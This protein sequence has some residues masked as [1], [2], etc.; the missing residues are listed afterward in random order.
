MN[1]IPS[2]RFNTTLRLFYFLIVTFAGLVI[3]LAA[4]AIVLRNGQTAM[5]LRIATVIQDVCLFI[6]PPVVTAIIVSAM[7]A[8]LLAVD[9]IPSSRTCVM[10]FLAMTCSIP[11]MNAL[12]AWNEGITL[13]ESLG[14]IEQWMHDSED[15]AQ[16]QVK[17][18]LGGTTM[19]DLVLN[20]LIVGML[21]GF[22]EEIFFRG[23]LQRLL[24]AG[25]INVHLAIWI[26]A[27]LF[28][29]FHIQ[30]YGFFP[31]LLL[32]AFFGYALV[33][34]GSLWLPV[35]LHAFNNSLVVY[36]TW[37]DS[38]TGEEA[39]GAESLNA[40]GAD[41]TLMIIVSII[42]TICVLTLMAQKHAK[43]CRNCVKSFEG[44]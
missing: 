23:G 44:D 26:T 40:W 29:A 5:T 18:M 1:N 20:I 10:A 32:G 31:R 39:V 16:A 33:W 25:K 41:S 43:E 35:A 37:S 8:G 15:A 36:S 27:F 34:S 22:S 3:A 14:V 12:V 24:S 42:L 7:P 13:P 9:S 38:L 30:F 11:A 6:L 21:A 28:S 2:L 19:G 17:I 4:M